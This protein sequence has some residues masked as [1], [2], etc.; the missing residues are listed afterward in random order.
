[1]ASI[2]LRP[3]AEQDILE[4]QRWYEDRSPG[5][6]PGFLA[7]VD[8]TIARISGEPLTFPAVHGS[9]RRAAMRRF[10]YGIYFRILPNHIIVLAV[11]HGGRHPLRWQR[12][13]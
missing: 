4:A 5:L 11:M 6:G 7:A 10:P 3:E 9:T 8:D 13:R 1:M 2:V 12:R